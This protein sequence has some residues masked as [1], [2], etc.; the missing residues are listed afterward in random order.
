MYPDLNVFSNLDRTGLIVAI[1]LSSLSFVLSA[2]G[3][4]QARRNL[5]LNS[6]TQNRIV[7]ISEVRK[8]L[9][10]FIEF[11]KEGNKEKLKIQMYKIEL[12]MRR[13]V[14][15]YDNL[16]KA[17]ENCCNTD[18]CEGNCQQLIFCA[19]DVLSSVWI[20]MKR[21]A[22]MRKREDEQLGLEGE[23]RAIKG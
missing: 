12:Y 22:G 21:E 19:Q 10:E 20:R 3:I 13:G 1:V 18:Y 2:I 4:Y 7:W 11:Y 14:I 16:A 9:V 17:M 15:S 6:I 5:I 8:L 23:K